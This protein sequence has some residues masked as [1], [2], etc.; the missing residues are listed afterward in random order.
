MN[1]YLVLACLDWQAGEAPMTTYMAVPANGP[2]EA[3]DMAR[4]RQADARDFRVREVL[5]L[6]MIRALGL[7]RDG[8]SVLPSGLR[9]AQFGPLRAVN[10]VLEPHPA[11][12]LVNAC[13]HHPSS[14]HRRP[15]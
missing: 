2:E 11:Y 14:H 12:S 9:L 3:L 8:T 7:R 13:P 1:G 15:E 4:Q 10:H 5:S 6:G